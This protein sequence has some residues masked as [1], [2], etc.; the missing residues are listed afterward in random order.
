MKSEKKFHLNPDLKVV[1]VIVESLVRSQSTMPFSSFP[2][3][4][5]F[6]KNFFD[7][8]V[9]HDSDNIKLRP[10]MRRNSFEHYG[11]FF[12]LSSLTLRGIFSFAWRIWKFQSTKSVQVPHRESENYCFNFIIRFFFLQNIILLNKS[13]INLFAL[14]TGRRWKFK[15]KLM[16]P[17]DVKEA[18]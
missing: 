4:A 9:T 10:H 17:H 8:I 3:N 1:V 12:L 6:Q 18:W 14:V 2:S 13:K 7:L 5:H 15:K 16:T 11:N